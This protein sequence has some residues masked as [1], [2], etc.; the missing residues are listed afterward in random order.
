MTSLTTERAAIIALNNMGDWIDAQKT[1]TQLRR[2]LET[3]RHAIEDIGGLAH[4]CSI[5]RSP[6]DD[7]LIADHIES[8]AS[9]AACT[10]QRLRMGGI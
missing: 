6:S 2:E 4:T 1:I 5:Q 3:L 10:L 9:I 8:I 7:A